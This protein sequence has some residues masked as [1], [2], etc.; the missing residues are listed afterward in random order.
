MT[1]ICIKKE[2]VSIK[3]AISL[4]DRVLLDIMHKDIDVE[5]GQGLWETIGE[6]DGVQDVDYD[7]HF[8]NYIYV[9][10]DKEHDTK[11]T[12]KLIYDLINQYTIITEKSEV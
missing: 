10:I 11:G 3:Y 8:G 1:N 5:E 6:V 12:W 9:E 4:K 2:A 7:G